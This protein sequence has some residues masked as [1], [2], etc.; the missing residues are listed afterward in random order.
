MVSWSPVLGVHQ[1]ETIIK[2]CKYNSSIRC[3]W[4]TC[5]FLDLKGNVRVCKWHPNPS[6]RFKRKEVTVFG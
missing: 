1:E 2:K 5:G 3:F 6:G 4:A